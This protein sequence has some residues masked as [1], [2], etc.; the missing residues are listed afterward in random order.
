MFRSCFFWSVRQWSPCCCKELSIFWKSWMEKPLNSSFP[1]CTLT[2]LC[3][4]LFPPAAF[5]SSHSTGWVKSACKY[6]A[7]FSVSGCLALS[8]SFPVA[9][10]FVYTVFCVLF[11]THYYNIEVETAPGLA[12]LIKLIRINAVT[13]KVGIPLTHSLT[14]SLN[15]SRLDSW[16]M[17]PCIV[18]HGFL[19]MREKRKSSH[20]VLRELAPQFTLLWF[21]CADV[22]AL[23]FILCWFML[24]YPA[25]I[26]VFGLFLARHVLLKD[27]PPST[28]SKWFHP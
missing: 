15:F 2:H 28:V 9:V 5:S 11:S 21:L 25:L 24:T 16:E 10:T 23:C 18:H 20:C 13:H 14:V 1:F 17:M 8:V 19:A 26:P 7:Q 12:L 3:P 4:V 22:N 27:E 6:P